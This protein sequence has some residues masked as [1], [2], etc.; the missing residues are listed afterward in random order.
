MG[1]KDTCFGEKYQNILVTRHIINYKEMFAGTPIYISY[2]VISFVIFTS[3][4]VI[5]LF[6]LTQ[7]RSFLERLFEYLPLYIPYRSMVYN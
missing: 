7:L 2:V 5:E 4:I 6:Y 3:T 1:R